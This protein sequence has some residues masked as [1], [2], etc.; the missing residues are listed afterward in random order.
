MLGVC[1]FIKYRAD[2]VV[3]GRRC[4]NNC[5]S[6]C[7]N[8]IG[9]E[10]LSARTLFLRLKHP[11]AIVVLLLQI[12]LLDD[13]ADEYIEEDE[14]TKHLAVRYSRGVRKKKRNTVELR[15]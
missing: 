6:L 13:D 7:E 8:E 15:C 9:N 11:V 10:T 1:D 2:G 14:Y 4:L 12:I 5:H 3:L